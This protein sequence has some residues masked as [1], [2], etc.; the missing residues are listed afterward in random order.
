MAAST[1]V[2][3]STGLRLLTF[4]Q[5]RAPG[6]SVDLITAEMSEVFLPA[7]G[8][9]LEVDPVEVVSMVAVVGAIR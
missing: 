8:P 3:D 5:E 6:R 9:A 4:S 1:M 7:G 2:A